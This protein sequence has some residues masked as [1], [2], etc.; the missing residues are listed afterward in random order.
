M[1]I[2]AQPDKMSARQS[3]FDAP[4]WSLGFRPFYLL[5]SI[6]A[7]LLI[8]FWVLHLS[9]E[10]SLY[11]PFSGPGWHAHELVF[12]FAAAILTGFLFTAVRNWTG[13][14]TPSGASLAGLAAIW[15]LARILMITGP[16]A[17]ASIVDLAFLPLM[18]TGII[19]PIWQSGNRRNFVV[20]ALIAI[21]Y[22]ANICAHAGAWEFIEYDPQLAI[23]IGLN[24]FAL[25]ITIIAGRVMPMFI[26]NAVPGAGAGRIKPIE[27]G[28]VL[29]MVFVLIVETARTVFPDMMDNS[30]ISS[31]YALL[32]LAL[33]GLHL[34]RLNRWRVFKSLHNPILW[35][36]PLSYFWLAASVGFKALALL[37]TQIDPI[38]ATHML[39]VGAVGGMMIGMMT[40][41]ALGHTGRA[42]KAGPV[43]TICFWL[44][45]FA[46]IARVASI[47][48]PPDYYLSLLTV[49]AFCWSTAFALFAIRYWPFVTRPRF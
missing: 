6:Y 8:P 9:G 49:A 24:V 3:L 21:L 43:E 27:L 30:A 14:P 35:I 28:T 10:V 13:K 33:T 39:G 45:Q 11:G 31:V 2:P 32:L 26:N 38:I 36:M 46:V 23:S 44:I 34:A 17:L 5:G 48:A 16:S 40:R 47:V 22:I 19:R 18:A 1:S 15:L 7:A 29:G 20:V 12:G 37:V 42:V 4:V 25:F 41:S